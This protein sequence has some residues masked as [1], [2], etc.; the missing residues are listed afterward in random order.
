M[1]Q[2]KRSATIGTIDG[3]PAIAYLRSG[4]AK[5]GEPSTVCYWRKFVSV[6]KRDAALLDEKQEVITR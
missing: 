1:R 2:Y 3:K 6:D 4:N 5:S